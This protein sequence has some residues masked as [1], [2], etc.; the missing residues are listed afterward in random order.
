MVSG[1]RETLLH[2]I[3]Y[4]ICRYHV[5][6]HETNDEQSTNGDLHPIFLHVAEANSSSLFTST[7]K[8]YLSNKNWVSN[9]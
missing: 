6:P 4:E 9:I 7:A 8:D 5:K 2:T 3:H 1:W